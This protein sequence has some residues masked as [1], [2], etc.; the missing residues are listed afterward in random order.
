MKRLDEPVM[1]QRSRKIKNWNKK[2]DLNIKHN[3]GRL[4]TQVAD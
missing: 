1:N 4:I 2:I 3:T